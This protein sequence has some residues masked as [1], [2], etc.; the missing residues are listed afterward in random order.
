[1][2]YPWG[3]LFSAPSCFPFP[4]S[5]QKWFTCL[6]TLSYIHLS[7]SATLYPQSHYSKVCTG[8]LVSEYHAVVNIRT[9][10][11]SATGFPEELTFATN[12]SKLKSIIFPCVVHYFIEQEKLQ[13]KKLL[14]I[15]TSVTISRIWLIS[16]KLYYYTCR[17]NLFCFK[18]ILAT[19]EWWLSSSSICCTKKKYYLHIAFVNFLLWGMFP[20]TASLKNQRNHI[21]SKT[22]NSADSTLSIKSTAWKDL[23]IDIL[24]IF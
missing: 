17:N 24:R 19:L 5:S 8:V 14:F 21:I 20:R 7:H 16:Y 9:G 1:M 15:Y 6:F 13:A 2:S 3:L 18:L 22:H 4:L 11:N 23:R 10:L 12:M